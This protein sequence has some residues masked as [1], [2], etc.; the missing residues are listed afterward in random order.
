MFNKPVLMDQNKNY[1]MFLKADGNLTSDPY[2]AMTVDLDD[3]NSVTAT[4]KVVRTN[5]LTLSD[6]GRFVVEINENENV[7]G[8]G[9]TT[10]PNKEFLNDRNY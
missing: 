2:A 1:G 5:R 7:D 6:F 9:E 10:D 4:M 3:M 8:N